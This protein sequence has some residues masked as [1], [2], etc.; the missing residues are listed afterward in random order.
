MCHRRSG[1]AA[2]EDGSGNG[3]TIG[4]RLRS[5]AARV[6]AAGA[7]K[8]ATMRLLAGLASLVLA[9]A[10]VGCGGDDLSDGVSSLRDSISDA[11]VDA[12][13]AIDT[14]KGAAADT[15]QE[16]L[17]QSAQAAGVARSAIGGAG[18]D[19]SEESR[20][21]LEQAQ[22]QLQPAIDDLRKAAGDASGEARDA[23]DEALADLEALESRIADALGG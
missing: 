15:A 21:A 23:L 17:N 5:A 16:A 7:G 12:L 6:A 4:Y 9:L 14:A 8:L 10:V 2:R 1:D 3:R 13:N 20:D 18:D 11:A 19:L 22:E